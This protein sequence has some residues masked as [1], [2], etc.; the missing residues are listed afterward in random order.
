MWNRI[1]LVNWWLIDS[2]IEIFD[3]VIRTKFNTEVIFKIV[4]WLIRM[5]HC[6]C[7]KCCPTFKW[8]ENK[9]T[10]AM[11]SASKLIRNCANI[12]WRPDYHIKSKFKNQ[13]K[14]FLKK[15][16]SKNLQIGYLLTL[17]I[18]Y[19]VNLFN[20]KTINWMINPIRFWVQTFKLTTNWIIK[21]Q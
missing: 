14:S 2:C 10:N 1:P 4:G 11:K 19:N 3:D 12:L 7:M 13:S 18:F 8:S 6:R 20:S 16:V 9:T 5:V 21:P 17:Q 15:A